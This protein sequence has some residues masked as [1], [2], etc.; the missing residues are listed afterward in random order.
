MLKEEVDGR[1]RSCL[2]SGNLDEY[3]QSWSRELGT[4]GLIKVDKWVEDILVDP[5]SKARL[6]RSENQLI[7]DYGRRYHIRDGI[8]DLRVL[9]QHIGSQFSLWAHGQEEF[10][11]W[12]KEAGVRYKE[13][14][15]VEERE[16]VRVVYDAIPILGRCIDIGG[17][18]GRLRAYL[19]KEQ[20]YISVDPFIDAFDDIRLQENLMAAYPFLTEPVNFVS[21]LAEHLP[22]Q[23]HA[24]D[25]A[26]MRSCIDH[27]YNPEL[28]LLEAHRVLK[29]GGQLVVGLYVEGGRTGRIGITKR[30]KETVR[31]V[32]SLV[33]DAFQD[34]HMWHPTY[35]ELCELI[36]AC[37]FRI[38]MTHW[39]KAF[40]DKVC[41]LKAV[42]ID[43]LN[44]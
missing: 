29:P 18:Q 16:S 34:H 27:F 5:L 25:T 19:S 3:W 17:H 30:S 14:E 7:S 2:E 37:G 6:R 28:A 42:K 9:T 11:R 36:E 40:V 38:E 13:Q 1:V 23:S 41:Y 12:S 39:Q 24:F 15:Y 8:Y 22:F 35:T 43:A 21:A 4:L 44:G 26:H 31:R 20:E 33:T 32:L 10:E